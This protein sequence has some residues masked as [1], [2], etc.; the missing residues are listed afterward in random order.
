MTFGMETLN[1][2]MAE[3]QERVSPFSN[4]PGIRSAITPVS[5]PRQALLD[6]HNALTQK[7]Y[8]TM[9]LK[10][11]NYA[12]S[13][14]PFRNFRM[15]GLIGI[16]V[17]MSDKLCRLQVFEENGFDN[18]GDESIEDTLMDLINYCVLFGALRNEEAHGH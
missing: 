5:S 12:T 17:R 7:A 16:L 2:L 15:F 4:V 8:D 14:D 18:I 9:V 6:L 13:D 1:K 11:N 10:N 3:K